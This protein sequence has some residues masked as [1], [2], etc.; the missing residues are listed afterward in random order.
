MMKNQLI[1]SAVLIFLSILLGLPYSALGQ[2]SY[3]RNIYATDCSL[4]YVEVCVQDAE[5]RYIH[6]LGSGDFRIYE[7][8]L[9][10][11]SDRFR[12]LGDCPPESSLVDIVL[13]LDMSISMNDETAELEDNIPV[14][15]AGLAG[16]DYRI[17][18]VRYNGCEEEWD[19]R[20]EVVRTWYTGGWRCSF[21]SS[22][23]E[24]WASSLDEFECI[25][26]ASWE[27]TG[28]SGREEDQYG[29]VVYAIDNLSFRSGAK[30]IFILFTDERPQVDRA[31]EPYLD[32]TDES[33]DSIVNILNRNGINFMPV[34]PRDGEFFWSAGDGDSPERR[35]YTGYLEAAERTGGAWF[36]LYSADYSALVDSI[37]TEIASDTCCYFLSYVTPYFCT[38][39][40]TVSVEVTGYGISDS[41]YLSFCPPYSELLIPQPPGGITT[42]R[43]QEILIG[44]HQSRTRV[45]TTTLLL[46]VQGTNYSFTTSPGLSWLQDS[47]LRYVP[48]SPWRHNDTVSFNLNRAYDD[49][50]CPVGLTSGSFIVDT[51]PP[52]F[53][54]EIPVT[55]SIVMTSIPSIMVNIHDDLAGVDPASA[56]TSHTSV[57]VN[58][59]T[60]SD[61]FTSWNGSALRFDGLSFLN[62]DSVNICIDSVWDNPDYDYCPS[63]H[64]FFCWHFKVETEGPLAA[65]IRPLPNTYSACVNQDIIITIIDEDGIV[66]SSILLQVGGTPFRTTSPLLGFEAGSLLVFR[67]DSGFWANGQVVEVSLLEAR[68]IYGNELQNPVAWSF[69]MDFTP[70]VSSF[71]QPGE[72][73]IQDNTPLF[74]MQVYDSLSGTQP[75]S[76]IVSINQLELNIQEFHWDCS[77]DSQGG[78]ISINTELLN[79]VFSPGDTIEVCLYACDRPDYCPPNCS[80]HCWTF[81]IEPLVACFVHPNPFTPNGDGYNEI[82]IFD[83]PNMFS[84][85]AELIIFSDRNVEVWRTHIESISSYSDLLGRS[86]QGLDQKGKLLPEGLYI[87]VIEK[88]GKVIC[89]GTLILAR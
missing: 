69:T 82:A 7:N 33:L 67:P 56:I 54:N 88:G 50:G 78:F 70:P 58:G 16:M 62:G 9:P 80:R 73:M 36:H 81:F 76:V 41:F 61:Y 21:G 66:E 89:N 72:I 55:N 52:E 85:G 10:I 30:I 47:I 13:L 43:Y 49:S 86:W 18:I 5:G 64:S 14:F 48:P 8:S 15:V 22:A 12:L 35:F 26:D 4:V 39:L 3:I 37:A 44:F 17:A 11:S 51:L 38:G 19:G 45:D 79:I 60:R 83:Y 28:G 27:V 20:R 1:R 87:Y 46:E 84:E 6:G 63:N 75:E 68:D 31:C 42:C 71:D 2:A 74:Y 25:F 57:L 65:I 32:Y 40:N 34:T 23:P 77:E 53:S 59:L 24:W 29:A